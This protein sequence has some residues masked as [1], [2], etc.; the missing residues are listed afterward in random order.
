M[1]MTKVEEQTFVPIATNPEIFFSLSPKDHEH[2]RSNWTALPTLR[3]R[4]KAPNEACEEL[5]I[6]TEVAGRLYQPLDTEPKLQTSSV[7]S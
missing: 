4:T 1:C 3:Q 6:M 2:D 7:K 5:K